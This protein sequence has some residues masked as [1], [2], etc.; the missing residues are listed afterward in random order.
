MSAL[1]IFY[2]ILQ[3]AAY[4]AA[5]GTTAASRRDFGQATETFG[6]QYS[7]LLPLPHGVDTIAGFI[8]WR[9][10]GALPILFGFWALLSAAGATRGDEERGLI[11]QWL[12]SGVGRLRY[13]LTRFIGFAISAVIAVTL[14]S[15]AIDTGAASA[16]SSGGGEASSTL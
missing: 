16:G 9:V 11:E 14:T 15:A 4:N 10:Y 1:G 12:A 5:A 8:Q 3:A 13:L 2:G 6:R 7:L